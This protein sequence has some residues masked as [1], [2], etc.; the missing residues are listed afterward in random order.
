M[1]LR[2]KLVAALL[3]VAGVSTGAGA[4]TF[5]FA[6]TGAQFGTTH[7]LLSSIHVNFAMPVSSVEV[8]RGTGTD[9]IAESMPSD[10]FGSVSLHESLTSTEADENSSS[11]RGFFSTG[12]GRASLLGLVGLAGAGFVAL[13]SGDNRTSS[14]SVDNLSLPATAAAGFSAPAAVLVNPEPATMALLA[15]G[16]GTIGL[17]TRHRRRAR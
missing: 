11:E 2:F 17:V 10:H 3:T 4:Q 15:L 8:G 6:A 7:E 1:T 13:N 5:S 12:T 9:L 16:L 14:P